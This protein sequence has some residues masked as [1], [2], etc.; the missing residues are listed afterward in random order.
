MAPADVVHTHTRARADAAISCIIK[1]LYLACYCA[2]V[3]ALG[4]KWRLHQLIPVDKQE[5]SNQLSR[6]ALLRLLAFSQ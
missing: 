1:R 6:R 2:M 4:L 3:P 5:T